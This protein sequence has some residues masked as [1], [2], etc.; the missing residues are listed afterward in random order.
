MGKKAIEIGQF[1]RRNG[2]R[3]HDQGIAGLVDGILRYRKQ[4]NSWEPLCRVIAGA[5]LAAG[6]K[7]VKHITADLLRRTAKRTQ[8]WAVKG[9][10]TQ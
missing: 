8:T 10:M 7:D 3:D 4:F 1:L 5:Y 2:R 6:I 9:G